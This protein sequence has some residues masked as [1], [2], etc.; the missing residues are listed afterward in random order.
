MQAEKMAVIEAR[1]NQLER[2]VESMVSSTKELTKELSKLT[3]TLNGSIS[4]QRHANESL[5]RVYEKQD[6]TDARVS[7]IERTQVS[8]KPWIDLVQSINN[9]VWFIVI[10]MMFTAIG[11]ISVISYMLSTGAA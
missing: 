7:A 9:R 5:V 2:S 10:G 11:S 4:E 6:K 1:Q 8:Y 3:I